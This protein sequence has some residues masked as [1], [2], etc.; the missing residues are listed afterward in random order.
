MTITI[1]ENHKKP[2]VTYA[3]NDAGLEL[4]VVD[5]THPAFAL[6]IGPQELER[7]LQAHL[8]ELRQREKVPQFVQNFMLRRMMKN[9]VLMRAIMGADGGF[10]SGMSTY[11]LKLGPD[12]M[13]GRYTSSIDRQIS[14]SL[15]GLSMRIRLQDITRL[16]ANGLVPALTSRKADPLHL[17]NIGGG[18]AIDS[19]NA[20][21]ILRKERPDLLDGRN[22][23]IHILDV[24][25]AGPHFGNRAL[26][27]LQA[28][29]APLHGLN[30]RLEHV[31]YNWTDTTALTGLLKSLGDATPVVAASSE[32]ALFEYG[33]D[34]EITANLRALG[35]AAS[36]DAIFVG[37]VTRA[38]ATGRLLNASSRAAL[39]LRGI[40][41]FSLLAEAAGWRVAERSDSPMSHN[42]LLRKAGADA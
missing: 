1:P 29:G 9:S 25:E 21:L 31:V 19:L 40:E 8:R 42:V 17:L 30:I 3:L 23:F 7:R 15:P 33:S 12:N 37:S 38:D 13:D 11:L 26:A 32:G 6:D 34:A 41:A 10:L 27:A 20:L 4:P 24:D 35:E 5:V 16:L 14:A 39:Q 18:P 36:S 28:E 22:I 2:G